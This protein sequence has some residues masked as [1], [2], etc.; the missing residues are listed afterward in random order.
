MRNSERYAVG[1]V[2]LSVV[3]SSDD[4]NGKTAGNG[5]IW[6]DDGSSDGSGVSDAGGVITG[7]VSGI[8]VGI[9]PNKITRPVGVLTL[10]SNESDEAEALDY[11]KAMEMMKT[12]EQKGHVE[13]EVEILQKTVSLTKNMVSV[14]RETITASLIKLSFYMGRIISVGES[15]GHVT[16]LLEP[17][18]KRQQQLSMEEVEDVVDVVKNL[19]KGRYIWGEML[20][21]AGHKQIST[22]AAANFVRRRCS[23]LQWHPD[24][25]TQIIVASDDDNS[26]SSKDSILLGKLN[27]AFQKLLLTSVEKEWDSAR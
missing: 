16:C 5:G 15:M 3:S 4:K 1:G 2:S 17:Q 6:P 12:L 23:V 9:V 11:E 27:I 13:F 10:S 19:T 24:V 21:M 22:S 8:V 20:T 14:S 7:V 26:P 18:G 25:A